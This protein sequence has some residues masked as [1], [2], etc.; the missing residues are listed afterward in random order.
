MVGGVD[1]VELT[2][3]V[4][5]QKESGILYNA[6]L[7]RRMIASLEES[8]GEDG[9]E[10]KMRVAGFDDVERITGGELIEK[11]TDAYSE[12]GEDEVIILCRSN[13]RAIRYNAGIRS[14]VQFKEKSA[15]CVMT[16]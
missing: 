13:K 4:R 12:Y 3:V 6:T 9:G 15:W 7:V 16:S 11:I 5:Q 8:Y 2:T 10:L 14:T 1:F